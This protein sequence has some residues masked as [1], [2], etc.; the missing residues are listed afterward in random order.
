MG[1][2]RTARGLAESLTAELLEE[3]VTALDIEGAG[4]NDMVEADD[5]D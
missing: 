5:L 4:L 1:A 3:P 2:A